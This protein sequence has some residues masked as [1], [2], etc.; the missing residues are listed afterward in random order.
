MVE[1]IPPFYRG[2]NGG[3]QRLSNVV[4]SHSYETLNVHAVCLLPKSM[5]FSTTLHLEERDLLVSSLCKEV[6]HGHTLWSTESTSKKLL[7][8]NT[9]SFAET[10]M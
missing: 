9:N 1:G 3:L 2:K 6:S 7:S 8:I 10:Y 5:L 4:K